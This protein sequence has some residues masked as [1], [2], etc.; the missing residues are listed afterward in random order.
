[1]IS[2][3]RRYRKVFSI[4]ARHGFDDVL[5]SLSGN[6][7]VRFFRRRVTDRAQFNRERWVRLR[8]AL[9]EL[10]PTYV[11]FGQV[12]SNRPGLLPDDLTAELAKLQDAVPPFPFEEVERLFLAEFGKPVQQVF[13]SFDPV[14]LASASIAQVHR[15]VLFSGERWR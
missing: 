8:L 1:M 12:L 14:Q 13:S 11:K 10:G 3:G 9:E 2:R 7:L 15:A 4:L 5:A 6:R